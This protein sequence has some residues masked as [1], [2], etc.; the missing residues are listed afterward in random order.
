MLV[1]VAQAGKSDRV[2][3]RTVCVR[4]DASKRTGRYSQRVLEWARSLSS[5]S[6]IR[7]TRQNF[8]RIVLLS[9]TATHLYNVAGI[10]G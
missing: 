5:G 2:H 1:R 3:S 8:V 4:D 10:H 9:F 7:V 6:P